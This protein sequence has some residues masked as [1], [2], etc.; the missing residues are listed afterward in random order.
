[1]VENPVHEQLSGLSL[2][3]RWH[4]LY[5][6]LRLSSRYHGE[7]RRFFARLHHWSTALAA[8]L[9]SA[10]FVALLAD[11]PTWSSLLLSGIVAVTA[12]VDTAIGF[13]ARANTYGELARRFIELEREFIAATPSEGEYT[14]LLGARRLIEA[15]EPPALPALVQR[16]HRDLMRLDG[17]PE[18]AWP[19]LGW[20]GRWFAQVLPHA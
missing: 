9:G 8:L 12:A 20:F 3:E 17:H 11:A 14:R 1:M 13:S 6:D 2:K 19:R 16:C 18:S 5:F 7:R 15:D 4:V 10:T